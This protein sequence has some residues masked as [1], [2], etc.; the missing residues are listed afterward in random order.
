[1]TLFTE[2]ADKYSIHP[3]LRLHIDE[4]ID[5]DRGGLIQID[6]V[7][8]DSCPELSKII[9]NFNAKIFVYKLKPHSSYGWVNAD[10]CNELTTTISGFSGK[11]FYGTPGRSPRIINTACIPHAMDT[12]FLISRGIKKSMISFGDP[13]IWLSINIC[14][15]ELDVIKRHLA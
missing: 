8:F 5:L 4:S 11:Y 10:M 3:S 6:P 15:V 13:V 2:I 7:W 1:M 9:N 14:N 12:W